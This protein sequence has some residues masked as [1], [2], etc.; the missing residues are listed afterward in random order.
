MPLQWKMKLLGLST[1]HLSGKIPSSM[2][3]LNFLKGLN[4]SYNN[5]KG[6]ILMGTQL[7]SFNASAFE[8]TFN[9]VAVHFQMS[10][11][12]L[13]QIIRITST[14]MRTMNEMSFF[15]FIFLQPQVS[16]SDFGEF[17]VLQF[18][19]RHG[20]MHIFSSSIMYMIRSM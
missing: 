7:Q 20:G 4:I 16:L 6:Q 10:A 1:N 18:L 14:K 9:F 17:S 13:M 2:T 8:G 3:S 19:T 15:G 12:T 11:E 5:L